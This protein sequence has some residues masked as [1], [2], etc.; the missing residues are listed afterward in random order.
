MEAPDLLLKLPAALDP[1]DIVIVN[2]TG[3]GAIRGKQ[4]ESV[5]V[6]GRWRIEIVLEKPDQHL[7]RYEPDKA[8]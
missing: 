4:S 8:G 7:R 3:L 5:F 6:D 2:N 1:L